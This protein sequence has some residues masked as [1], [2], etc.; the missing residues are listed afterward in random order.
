[1]IL[2]LDKWL[3]AEKPLEIYR[4]KLEDQRED[5]LT[6]PDDEESTEY[7]EVPQADRKGGIDPDKLPI[8]VQRP[9]AE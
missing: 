3:D 7:G 9:Y 6:N 5:D 8:G 2:N 4:D 1:L